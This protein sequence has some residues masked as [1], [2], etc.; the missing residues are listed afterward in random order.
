MFTD[1]VTQEDVGLHLISH[2]KCSQSMW[3]SS[4]RWF[5][6]LCLHH[7]PSCTI[8]LQVVHARVLKNR[9]LFCICDAVFYPAVSKT[10]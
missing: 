9:K 1:S 10:I 6:K 2:G 8:H 7:P 3:N 4:L 5:V